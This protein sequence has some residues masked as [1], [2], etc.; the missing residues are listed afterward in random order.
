MIRTDN[1]F[2]GY[3]PLYLPDNCSVI[4]MNEAPVIGNIAEAIRQA[5][6]DPIGSRPLSEIA[7]SKK[8][9]DPDAT[10][11]ILVSDN[12]RPVPYTG[13]PGIL[14]PIVDVLLSCGFSPD[15]ITVLIATGTH[16]AMKDDEIRRMLDPRVFEL[17]LRV[18]NHD[19][20]DDSKLVNI[21][22]TRRGTEVMID[23]LYMQSDLKIA[24]GLIESHFMAGASGGR[25][26]VCPGVIGEKTTY[27]FHGPELMADPNSRDLL[28]EGNP[29]HQES[30]EVAL[31]AGVDFLA[32]VTLN[33]RFEI[34]GLFF[35]DLQAAHIAGVDFIRSFVGVKVPRRSDIVITNAGFVGINHYQ[36]AKCAVASLGVLREGGWLVILADNTDSGDIVGSLRYKTALGLLKI[37]GPEGYLRAIC[38]PDWTFLPDQWQ[39]QQWAKV[40]RRIP[41]DHL[42][43][44]SPQL[45][46]ERFEPVPGIDGHR[47]TDADP[48]DPDCFAKALDGALRAISEAEG[49]RLGEMDI[50]WIAD[51]PYVVPHAD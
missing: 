8:A 30:L 37:F 42:I 33:H 39:V 17:G 41:M 9:A 23:S 27:L 7:A 5:L 47:F 50:T 24:T 15:E 29:V 3:G 26:A 31:M 21:G 44:F 51:G 10:A 43:F 25:K 12:T 2:T 19:C 20:R 45:T 48:G 28:I 13:E 49:R 32:N 16:R 4:R 18:V 36:C 22:K 46:G 1:P 40:F 38:S 34:T 11:V 6:R 14:M 35:G